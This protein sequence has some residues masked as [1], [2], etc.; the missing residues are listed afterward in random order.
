[1]V[2]KS[3]DEALSVEY[4]KLLLLN[5]PWVQ[6]LVGMKAHYKW[7]PEGKVWS[8][9]VDSWK[10]YENYT[11]IGAFESLWAHFAELSVN[12]NDKI[13][14]AFARIGEDENDIE[15]RYINEG[16]EL[17]QIHSEIESYFDN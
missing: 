17:V 3:D 12:G 6:I 5:E 1:M 14:G 16:Y 15:T 10:W 4:A 11:D 2:F 9:Q 13:H 7:K 8:L